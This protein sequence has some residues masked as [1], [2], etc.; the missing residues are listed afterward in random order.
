MLCLFTGHSVTLPWTKVMNSVGE[1]VRDL[2][3][4]VV[5]TFFSLCVLYV[6]LLFLYCLQR[7]SWAFWTESKQSGKEQQQFKFRFDF[8]FTVKSP[9]AGGLWLRFVWCFDWAVTDRK[10]KTSNHTKEHTTAQRSRLWAKRRELSERP[11]LW[12]FQL[13]QFS[14]SW[15]VVHFK[16]FLCIFFISMLCWMLSGLSSELTKANTIE[17]TQTTWS[18]TGYRK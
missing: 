9:A 14:S 11:P 2:G 10:L 3:W 6:I 13:D 18:L 17:L 15:Y 16:M 7:K 8:S 12:S 5:F 4:S 1:M